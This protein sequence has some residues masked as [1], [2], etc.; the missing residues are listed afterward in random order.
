M[1]FNRIK[2]ITCKRDGTPYYKVSLRTKWVQH[3]KSQE[4]KTSNLTQEEI[5]VVSSF[6]AGIT[7]PISPSF[8]KQHITKWCQHNQ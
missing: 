5:R 3:L 6:L 4:Q 1:T 8:L 7:T 2:D